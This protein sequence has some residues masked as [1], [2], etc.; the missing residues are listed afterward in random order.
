VVGVV[1]V[2]VRTPNILVDDRM[3][4]QFLDILRTSNNVL[5]GTKV[6]V[7]LVVLVLLIFT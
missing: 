6:V 3:K 2:V 4:G 1:P 7:P 5:F